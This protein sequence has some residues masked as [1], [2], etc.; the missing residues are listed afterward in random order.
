MCPSDLIDPTEDPNGNGVLDSGEDKN[1]NGEI[2]TV[3][4]G[5]RAIVSVVTSTGK[6][7]TQP[8]NFTDSDGNYL[9]DDPYLFAETEGQR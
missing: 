3:V 7:T 5:D 6:I 2:D 1:G 4:I 9:A 8:I